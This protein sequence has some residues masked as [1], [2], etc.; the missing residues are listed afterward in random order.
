MQNGV[1][2]RAGQLLTRGSIN[3]Y[4][5]TLSLQIETDEPVTPDFIPFEVKSLR[6]KFGSYEFNQRNFYVYRDSRNVYEF[7]VSAMN[8]FITNKINI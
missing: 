8:F 4:M 3:M 5:S 7:V 6:D 2:T 1:I